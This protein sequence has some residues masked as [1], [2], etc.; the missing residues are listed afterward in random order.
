MGN[1]QSSS[2]PETKSK[3]R[4]I[5]LDNIS[6]EVKNE[7]FAFFEEV[8]K[9]FIENYC[10]VGKDEMCENP[11]I[12]SSVFHSYLLRKL[13]DY[14]KTHHHTN[15][16][17]YDVYHL[18]N[19]TIAQRIT[20]LLRSLQTPITFIMG[21][22]GNYNPKIIMLNKFDKNLFEK[23]IYAEVSG[24]IGIRLKQNPLWLETHWEKN[25]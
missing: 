25:S 18:S 12:I 22:Y 8:S 2:Q 20:H 5:S 13:Q 24:M 7:A 11:L 6:D 15:N 19:V 21:S 23:D 14:T 9:E 17:I 4:I 1:K 16:D 3:A 10:V